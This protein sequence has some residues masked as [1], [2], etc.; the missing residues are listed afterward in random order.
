MTAKKDSSKCFNQIFPVKTQVILHGL[1]AAKYNN[2]KGIIRAPLDKK[3]DRFHIYIKDE[4]K[5]ILVKPI[6]IKTSKGVSPTF[7]L[8]SNGMNIPLI[9]KLAVNVYYNEVAVSLHYSDHL[10]LN[11]LK[12]VRQVYFYNDLDL[13]DIV[14][15]S[16]GTLSTAL[17]QYRNKP[18]EIAIAMYKN[19]D[20][21]KAMQKLG[22]IKFTGKEV[23]QGYGT[24]KIAKICF[25]K[26]FY[27]GLH[28]IQATSNALP[29]DFM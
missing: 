4:K 28:D 23:Q 25:Q 27:H 5:S 10:G 2:K 1:K 21:A 9:A 24:F 15:Q 19:A 29:S 3:L 20:M 7:I 26:M 16:F 12:Q 18:N 14:G 11:S 17:D 8:K 6:N 13:N 22:L